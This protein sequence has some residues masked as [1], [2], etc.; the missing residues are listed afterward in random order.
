MIIP[1]FGISHFYLKLKNFKKGFDL[2]ENRWNKKDNPG[3]K[4]FIQIP[5]LTSLDKLKLKKFYLG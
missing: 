2:Y 5:L 4:K 3:K 1:H